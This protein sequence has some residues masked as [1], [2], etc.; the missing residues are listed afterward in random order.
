[1]TS[2]N[3]DKKDFLYLRI[4]AGS[5]KVNTVKKIPHLESFSIERKIQELVFV[6]F[7]DVFSKGFFQIKFQNNIKKYFDHVLNE[8]KDLSSQLM[9][10]YSINNIF[11]KYEEKINQKSSEFPSNVFK[12]NNQNSSKF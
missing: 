11:E 5:A 9:I 12:Q 2:L 8:L 4:S 1:M 7:E 3:E 10:S 6:I